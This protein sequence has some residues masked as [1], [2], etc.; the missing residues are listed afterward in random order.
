M[1]LKVTKKDDS[2][3]LVGALLLNIAPADLFVQPAGKHPY[4]LN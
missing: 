4:S 3:Q 2:T 1:T